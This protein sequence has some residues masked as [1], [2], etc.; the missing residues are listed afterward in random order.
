[1]GASGDQGCGLASGSIIPSALQPHRTESVI[2]APSVSTYAT[3]PSAVPSQSAPS[4]QRTTYSSFHM[5]GIKYYDS[6]FVKLRS[7]N[8]HL[9]PFVASLPDVP[10]TRPPP[11]ADDQPCPTF[12]RETPRVRPRRLPSTGIPVSDH[13]VCHIRDRRGPGSFPGAI[14]ACLSGRGDHHHQGSRAPCPA[15]ARRP[16]VGSG[17]RRRW[18][19]S[20]YRTIFSTGR[21][22]TGRDRCRRPERC[23]RHMARTPGRFIGLLFDGH[24]V[25][26]WTTDDIRLSAFARG[27]DPRR[28]E[29]RFVRRSLDPRGQV[30]GRASACEPAIPKTAGGAQMQRRRGATNF[31]RK[32]RLGNASG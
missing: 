11:L 3:N 32:R 31:S 27:A 29:H 28:R 13:A 23:P 4:S 26:W 1:M 5:L 24:A 7:R 18:G 8:N 12:V 16:G 25:R 9:P 14:G 19:I 6:A 22:G 2:T 15:P 21:S 20:A 30:Q 17:R 10:A